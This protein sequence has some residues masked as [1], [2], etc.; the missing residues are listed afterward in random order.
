MPFATTTILKTLFKPLSMIWQLRILNSKWQFNLWKKKLNKNYK[1]LRLNMKVNSRTRYLSLILQIL[2]L[3]LHNLKIL[4]LKLKLQIQNFKVKL[5]FLLLK[6]KLMNYKL[7]QSLKN[8]SLSLN[9]NPLI[10][11][12]NL[13]LKL[14]WLTRRYLP[15]SKTSW[16]I[17]KLRLKMNISSTCLNSS[18]TRGLLLT[19]S[20]EAQIMD[21]CSKTF[22]IDVITR[23]LLSPCLRSRMA[24]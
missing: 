24:M 21:G 9:Q 16:Q 20:I 2:I 4:F 6:S 10:L 3:Y 18:E 14:N 15:W 23:G 13:L 22:I 5:L 12:L 8:L 17:H 1:K 7:N 19:C 11:N